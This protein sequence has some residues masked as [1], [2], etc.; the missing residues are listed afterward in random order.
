MKNVMGRLKKLKARYISMLNREKSLLAKCEIG[1][2]IML[3][4]K[5]EGFESALGLMGIYADEN[6][7]TITL[8]GT[9]LTLLN[10][11]T[12]GLVAKICE[13]RIAVRNFFGEWAEADPLKLSW[14]EKHGLIY[15]EPGAKTVEG[16]EGGRI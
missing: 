16:P 8:A 11:W 1:N 2:A 14:D 9:E 7:A 5:I 6:E 15:I 3:R 4:E 10:L 12:M 13:S